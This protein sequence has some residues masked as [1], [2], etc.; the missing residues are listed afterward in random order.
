MKIYLWALS[1]FFM[2]LTCS[3]LVLADEQ[4]GEE[5]AIPDSYSTGTVELQ[6]GWN[7]V[8]IPRR[9]AE[10]SNTA[11]VFSG[12]DSAGRSIWTYRADDGGWK[13]LAADSRLMPLD[14]YFIYSAHPATVSLAYSVDPLQVPPVKDLT[15]GWNLV[16]FSGASEA[17]ARDAL[18][19][20]RKSWTQVI[21][22]DP[23][24]QKTEETIIN[25]GNGTYA[26]SALLLPMRAYWVN[27]ETPCSLASIGA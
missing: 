9:L 26:D 23:V 5:P 7:L 1:L 4:A 3:V 27:S 8:G 21:G 2:L 6:Q 18:L 12:I 22:W 14:G 25:G 16:G 19:S 10:E 24:G 13:D 15:A 11:S 20:I 17:S